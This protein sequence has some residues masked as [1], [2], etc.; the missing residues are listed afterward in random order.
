MNNSS[1]P[2]APDPVKTAEAQTQSNK[3]TA[4]ANANLNRFNQFGPQGSVTWKVTGTNPDGTPIYEQY[5]NLNPTEQGIYDTNAQ[6]RAQVGQIGLDASKRM[7]ALLG[8]DFSVND[9]VEKKLFDLGS[10][11]LDPMF[12]QRQQTYEQDLAN[13]GIT[14]GSDAW[15][16]AMRTFDQGKNDAYN[17]LALSGRQ[18]AYTEASQDRARPI[19]E[20]TALMS[21]S[22]VD[23]PKF[24]G[25]TPV[26]QA[27]TDVAGITQNAYNSQ[28]AAWNAQQQQSNAMMGGLFGLGG[29]AM[30]FLPWSDARLKRDVVETGERGPLGLPVME[31]TYIWGGPRHRG[32]MAHDVRKVMPAAVVRR[33]NGF[34]AVDYAMIGG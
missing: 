12:A 31:W 8:T 18:Q 9:A 30:R 24:A 28:L 16:N 5:N 7:G 29:A 23:T 25:Y 21:G 4:I 34:D 22:Q 11:R 27:N 2:P 19:N 10:K 33:P 32:Y 3:E 20:L 6:T 14:M 13:K 26:T 1:R 17:Q 15:N